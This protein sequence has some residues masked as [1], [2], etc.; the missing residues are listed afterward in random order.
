M[1][2]PSSSILVFL[3]ATCFHED[4]D[5]RTKPA[6]E[7]IC[8]CRLPV[9]RQC[10]TPL[11]MTIADGSR[12]LYP[13]LGGALHKL[14]ALPSIMAW[15]STKQS[16][17]KAWGRGHWETTGRRSEKQDETGKKR[18][19]DWDKS[20]WEE[21]LEEVKRRS[22][23]ENVVE[24]VPFGDSE[25]VSTSSVLTQ[26]ISICLKACADMNCQSNTQI[27]PFRDGWVKE[28]Y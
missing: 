11:E 2:N 13:G 23:E 21:Q 26:K 6:G 28:N 19:R 9:A 3:T 5:L 7:P 12:R 8:A 17:W 27:L 4:E 22:Q 15:Q 18:R 10:S 1:C 14:S 25:P 24:Q 20:H 16:C